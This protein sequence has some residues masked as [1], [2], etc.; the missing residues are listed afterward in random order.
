MKLRIA[1][2]RDY[3]LLNR[4]YKL[5]EKEIDGYEL[6]IELFNFR[7]YVERQCIYFLMDKGKEIGFAIICIF[8]TGE[9]KILKFYIYEDQRR[10]GAGTFFYNR[11]E[12]IARDYGVEKISLYPANSKALA[13][14]ERQEYV[15]V[16]GKE[17]FYKVIR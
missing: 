17:L 1:D 6:G 5:F 14:W 11:L 13:F 8:D 7:V 10:T 2:V 3:A 12:Q 9:A 15:R 4:M 16:K